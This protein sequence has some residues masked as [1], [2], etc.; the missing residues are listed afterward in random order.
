MSFVGSM[1]LHMVDDGVS[2][3]RGFLSQSKTFENIG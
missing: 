3:P 2:E 1:G